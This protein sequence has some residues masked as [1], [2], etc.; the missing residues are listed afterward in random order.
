MAFVDVVNPHELEIMW[1]AQIKLPAS[2]DRRKILERLSS[3][4]YFL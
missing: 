4:L 2:A 3:L 1:L